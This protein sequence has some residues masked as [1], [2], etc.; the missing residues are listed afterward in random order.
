MLV[1]APLMQPA[2]I[3]GIGLLLAL[4]GGS[5]GWAQEPEPM[6]KATKPVIMESRGLSSG[7]AVRGRIM[8]LLKQDAKKIPP[9]PKEAVAPPFASESATN[10]QPVAQGVLE[11]EPFIVTQKRAIELPPR[12]AK[13]TL[14]NFFYGDGTIAQ[15][16]DKRFSFS[17]GPERKGLAA[18]KFNWKF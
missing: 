14:D 7:S 6:A 10:D 5:P 2:P 8:E 13:P 3:R 4:L 9:K 17:A 18:L 16:A 12:L 15:S 1:F 11:L